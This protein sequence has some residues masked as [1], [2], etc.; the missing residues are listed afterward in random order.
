MSSVTLR[1]P[2][3]TVEPY[4]HTQ[5]TPCAAGARYLHVVSL[6]DSATAGD[7][8]TIAWGRQEGQRGDNTSI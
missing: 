3:V 8:F 5:P 2:D 1:R 7:M 4:E 6:Q